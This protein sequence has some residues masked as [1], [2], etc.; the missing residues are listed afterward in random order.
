MVLTSSFK[1]Q[2]G[3]NHTIA[4]KVKYSKQALKPIK[5]TTIN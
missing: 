4:E 5:S 1:Y 2:L 3:S